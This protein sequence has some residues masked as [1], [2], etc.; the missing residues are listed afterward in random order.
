MSCPRSQ[1]GNGKL[2]CVFVVV[3]VAVVAVV[4]GEQDTR[5]SFRYLLQWG[6]RQ[7]IDTSCVRGNAEAFSCGLNSVVRRSKRNWR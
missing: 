4:I 6:Q 3:L 7:R 5:S 1:G 2:V